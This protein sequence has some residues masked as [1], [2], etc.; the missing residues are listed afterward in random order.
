MCEAVKKA[1]CGVTEVLGTFIQDLA[2]VGD[3]DATESSVRRSQRRRTAEH[4]GGVQEEG[5]DDDDPDYEAEE[6]EF[7]SSD[8]GSLGL[9]SEDEAGHPGDPENVP[10][11][12]EDEDLVPLST[13]LNKIKSVPREA[14]SIHGIASGT[15][16]EG[17]CTFQAQPRCDAP[18]PAPAARGGFIVGAGGL[19]PPYPHG[20]NGAP[21]Q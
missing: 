10:G 5:I 18:A 20:S 1:L 2:V 14:T 17:D 3:G 13:R 9:E 8:D 7:C 12:E 21:P 4:H 19:E 11:M 16:S 15:N 6:E